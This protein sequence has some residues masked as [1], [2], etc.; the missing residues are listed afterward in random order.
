MS[1]VV[2]G[3]SGF[4]GAMIYLPVAARWLSPFEAIT[5]LAVMEMI[6]PL[7]NVTRALR[8]A[9]GRDVVRLVAGMVI[10]LP[11]GVAILALVAAEVFRY[12]VSVSSFTLL[13]LLIGGVR[14]R[15][16]L[17]RAIVYTAGLLGGF[18]AGCVG[19]PGPPVIMLYMSATQP[20]KVIRATLMLYLL[21]ADVAMLA[22]LWGFGHLVFSAIGLGFLLAVPYL[23]GNMMGA[24]IFRPEN[25][26]TFR[27]VAYMII[28]VSGLSGLPLWD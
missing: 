24:R 23:L 11:F 21:L 8:D 13:A 14:Y 9:V 26:R 22:T 7:P 1:G 10:A 16:Q 28:A 3:F 12:G 4:G 25:E 18:T 17:S 27:A 6:G 2:R 15:G 5:T 20:P 19:L